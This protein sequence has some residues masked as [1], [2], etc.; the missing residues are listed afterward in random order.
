[1][2]RKIILSA[3]STCDLGGELQKQHHVHFYPFHI[4][5]EGKDY[6]DNVDIYPEQI[7]Q[8]WRERRQLP[9]TAA[10]NVS[11]YL[12][13]F[14]NWVEEGYDVIHL[15]LGGALSSAHQNCLLAAQELG[16]VYPV[17]SC[18]LSTGIGLLVLKASDMIEAGMEAEEIA[19][20]LR[21]LTSNVHASFILD[22]LEFMRAGG[23]CSAVTA[24]GANVLGLK[25]CIEV[26][27]TDGS[28]AVGKKYRGKLGKVLEN[29]VKDR[30]NMYQNIDTGRL[31]ITHSGI[32]EEYIRLV[33]KTVRGTM[34]FQNIYI[35]RASC[36]ISCH[37]GPNTLGILFMTK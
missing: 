20:N 7:Y 25:P 1:M 21:K 3:D 26:R 13:Y 2:E 37:C 14:R 22:T 16:H 24:F 36:T 32:D 11:E 33:E 18:N 4:I 12:D 17:N 28:M 5:L 15:N 31:F 8:A 19:A 9:K 29:Y 6:Q 10:I 35:T 27:N 30:L 34:E 23:R